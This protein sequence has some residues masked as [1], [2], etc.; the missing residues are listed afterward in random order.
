MYLRKLS[1]KE[2]LVSNDEPADRNES[3]KRLLTIF[4]FGLIILLSVLLS[5]LSEAEINLL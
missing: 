4:L 5:S 1:Y 2:D 3:K